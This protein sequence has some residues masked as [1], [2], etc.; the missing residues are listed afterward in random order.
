MLKILLLQLLILSSAQDS[1]NLTNSFKKFRFVSEEKTSFLEYNLERGV[2]SDQAIERS[3]STNTSA[4]SKGDIVTPTASPMNISRYPIS[5]KERCGEDISFPCSCNE[6][7]VVYRTCCEDLPETCTEL[8]TNALAKFRTLLS[9]SIR[10]DP[11]TIVFTVDSCPPISSENVNPLKTDARFSQTVPSNTL[12]SQ[13]SK[14]D[15]TKMIHSMSDILLNAPVT[16]YK[17][18]FVYSNATIYEC[19]KRKNYLNSTQTS[20]KTAAAWQ[21]HISDAVKTFT[22]E[23]KLDFSAYSYIPPDSHPTTAGSLCYNPT[24]LTCISELSTELAIQQPICNVSVSEYYDI[25]HD[26]LV[27]IEYYSDWAQHDVCAICLALYQSSAYRDN[28]F[29]PSG[30]RVLTSLDENALHV[31]FDLHKEWRHLRKPIPWWSWTCKIPDQTSAAADRECRVLQCD[32]RFLLTPDG[33]CRKAVEAEFAIQEEIM[34]KGKNCQ[35]NPNA[36]AE[37]TKCYLLAISKVTASNK[38]FRSYQTHMAHGNITLI[39]IRMEMYIDA[40]DYEPTLFDLFKMP[41]TFFPTLSLF[42]Q[43]FCSLENNVHHQDYSGKIS[44]SQRKLDSSPLKKPKEEK[45]SFQN[46]NIETMD[47]SADFFC[48]FCFQIYD[49]DTSLDDEII[50]H[51]SSK[52]DLERTVKVDTLTA[53]AIGLECLHQPNVTYASNESNKIGTSILP[54][55]AYVLIGQYLFCIAAISCLVQV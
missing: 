7:C 45:N 43:H 33:L 36:F 51:F 47:S 42:V 26:L 25:R 30:F 14:K 38:A 23:Q 37:I 2:F 50:C 29:F 21:A 9:A 10:C 49:I 27:M 5:C 20:V 18:G 54:F 40:E 39:T 32:E 55:L 22:I 48:S 13:S 44:S 52:L 1:F 28:R 16:D 8:Y 35:I 53:S 12:F 34:F 41:K 19:N 3:L 11:M 6:K 15:N 17:T 24:A 31:V 46:N 4:G